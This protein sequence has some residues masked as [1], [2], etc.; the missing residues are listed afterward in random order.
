MMG[1]LKPEE[2]L[3]HYQGDYTISVSENLVHA[4]TRRRPP[5]SRSLWF[6]DLA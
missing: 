5:L 4:P 3:G 2:A 6:P 1:A